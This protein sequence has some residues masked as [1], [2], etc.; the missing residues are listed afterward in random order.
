MSR[1]ASAAFE[2]STARRILFGAGVADRL[3]EIAAEFGRRILVVTGGHPERVQPLLHRL[4][5]QGFHLD[6]FQVN[7]EPTLHIVRAGAL[8]ARAGCELVLGIGGGAALDAAKA[9]SAMATNPGDVLDYM[10]VIGKAQPLTKPPLPCVAVPTTAGSGAEVTRNA[11]LSSPEHRVKASLRSLRLLPAVAIV[12]P[13]LTLSMPPSVTAATGMDALTQ[14]I[15]PFVSSRATPLTDTLC[16]E[17]IAR[18]AWALR[19]AYYDGSDYAAREAMSLVSLFGGLAL[20]NAGLGA[21]HGFAAPIGGMF[22]APHGAVCARLLPFVFS[23]NVRT[24]RATQPESPVLARF[25]EIARLLT[26]NPQA[27]A[28]DGARWLHD[29]CADLSIPPLRAYGIRLEDIPELADKAAAASSMRGNPVAFNRETRI[30]ILT[31]AL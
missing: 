31:E 13:R 4:S 3:G 14:V 20:A 28:E 29:L 22:V 9:I 27:S 7:G 26:G 25:D 2:F 23:A 18:A 30:A 1:S 19:R 10:E 21:V 15:E 5:E 12:D 16:R 8:R 6:L 17:A 11:V 24:L